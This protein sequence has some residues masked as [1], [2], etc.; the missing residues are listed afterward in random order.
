MPKYSVIVPAAGKSER[1]G[2]EAKKTFA[3]LDGRPMFIRALEHFINRE[4]VCQTI[5]TVAP[6]DIAAMKSS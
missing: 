5:L 6:E 2:G 3:K 1:F 4:D